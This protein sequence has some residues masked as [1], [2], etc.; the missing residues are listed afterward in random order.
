MGSEVHRVALD[1]EDRTH[2]V[3]TQGELKVPGIL[4]VDIS[5]KCQLK[6]DPNWAGCPRGPAQ[7]SP[8]WQKD[9][10]NWAVTVLF[11]NSPVRHE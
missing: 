3:G 4:I 2:F 5:V 8:T 6:C 9:V 11:S 1:Q 7:P 10:P